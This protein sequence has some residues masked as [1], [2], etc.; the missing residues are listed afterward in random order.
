MS[1]HARLFGVLC[2]AAVSFVFWAPTASAQVSCS[3]LPAFASC[4]AYASGTSVVFNNTKYTTVAAIPATRDCP[5]NAPYDPSSDNWWMNNGACSGGSATP[6]RTP[7]ATSTSAARATNTSTATATTGTA[8]KTPTATGTPTATAT[9]AA[10]APAKP[11][12][13]ITSVGPDAFD[14]TW[15]KWSGT[16]GTSW[17]LQENGTLVA[18]GTVAAAGGGQQTATYHATGK[19]YGV[20]TYVAKLIN[21]AGATASDPATTVTGGASTTVLQPADASKQ[22]LQVTMNQG[23]TDLTMSTIGVASPSYTVANN[24]PSVVTAS[25][26]GVTLHLS[27]LKAG[28]AGLKIVEAGGETRYVGIRVRTSSGALPRMPDWVSAGSV[29]ED[30]DADLGFWRSF[31]TGLTSKRCDIRYIYLNGGPTQGWRTWSGVDGG[32]A[33]TFIRESRKLGLIPF[34]VYYNIPDSSESYSLDLQHMQDAN[35]MG[36]YFKDL[37][38]F[39]DIAVRE[40]EDEMV[41][42]VLE[43]DSIGY[44]MQ[45]SGKQP[46]QITAATSAAYS[47]GVLSASDTQFPNTMAGLVQA[48]NYTIKKY[49][50]ASY[51]GWQVNLWSSSPGVTTPIPSNGLMHKTDTDGITAGRQEIAS[52]AAAIAN[53]YLA[54]GIKTNG[55]TFVS[56]DKYGL[57]AGSTSPADPSQ[58]PWFWNADHWNNY[59]T[60][61]KSLGDTTA[62][63]V[64][65]WQIP[66]GHVNTT[67][68]ANPYGGSFP[69]LDN[70]AQHYE[71]S[72][73]TFFLG[74]SFQPGAGVRLAWFSKN[75]GGDSKVTASG[76]TVTWGSHM[77]EAKAN[78][79]ISVLFGAGVGASTDGVA[80]PP[81]D[82]YWWIT[83]LQKYYQSPVPLP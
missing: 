24:N 53:Y 2:V 26:S 8:T 47:S 15:N 72:A 48:I 32:R 56:I 71:D 78:R 55:A 77:A 62:L 67:L 35:Y 5:P 80:S 82:G 66:V 41:G 74:D 61:T 38:F 13:L 14:V 73:P 18:S 64:V 23:T 50:P 76:A 4:T 11:I 21:S 60:F 19:G 58:S 63:P 42:I 29:S 68:A 12:L 27:G 16:D 33:I 30:T 44:M 10:G 51:F 3:G 83:A 34:F 9:T 75:Q 36:L 25:V 28:R 79:V 59:L 70:T 46:S 17:Q 37:K 52:E 54:A 49:A 6:T 31:G 65:L 45:N 1:S 22:A 69:V 7:T 20:F 43:P 40:G 57:D 39:L 81:T